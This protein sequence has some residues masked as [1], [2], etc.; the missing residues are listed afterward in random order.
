MGKIKRAKLPKP[1]KPPRPSQE[2]LR[3]YAD[4]THNGFFRYGGRVAEGLFYEYFYEGGDRVERVLQRAA[5][6]LGTIEPGM[7]MMFPFDLAQKRGGPVERFG[8]IWFEYW[9]TGDSGGGERVY[10]GDAFRKLRLLAHH[11]VLWRPDRAQAV[12]ALIRQLHAT[13][14]QIQVDFDALHRENPES[15]WVPG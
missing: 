8:Y 14:T 7:F 11:Y 4:A 15:Q 13:L 12:A 9:S 2:Q 1:G 10:F 3:A 5:Q 6:G